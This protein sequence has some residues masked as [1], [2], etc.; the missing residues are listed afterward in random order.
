MI[1]AEIWYY[2]DSESRRIRF[3]R[4]ASFSAVPFVGSI[5]EIPCGSLDVKFVR[6]HDGG[7]ITLVVDED[8]DEPSWKDSELEDNIEEKVENGW[9]VLSNVKRR[10]G[11]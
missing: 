9:T 3:S 6:F 10:R 8:G 2:I 5:I 7:G 1:D 4:K 11:R